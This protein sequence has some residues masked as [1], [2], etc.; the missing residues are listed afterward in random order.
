MQETPTLGMVLAQCASS[1]AAA[2]QH[3]R[4]SGELPRHPVSGLVRSDQLLTCGGPHQNNGG[5]H[6]ALLEALR[7]YIKLAVASTFCRP[8]DPYYSTVGDYYLF[9]PRGVDQPIYLASLAVLQQLYGL[10]IIAI[11][12]QLARCL[13]WRLAI[14]SCRAKNHPDV[15]YTAAIPAQD[16]SLISFISSLLDVW[17]ISMQRLGMLPYR[18]ATC[19]DGYMLPPHSLRCDNQP[20]Q[21]V[22]RLTAKDAQTILKGTVSKA[23]IDRMATLRSHSSATW[24]MYARNGRKT[25]RKQE[26]PQGKR[27][28]N[29]KRFFWMEDPAAA[30]QQNSGQA[31]PLAGRPV[32]EGAAAADSE[33]SGGPLPGSAAQGLLRLPSAAAV[34]AAAVGAGSL[35]HGSAAQGAAAVGAGSMSDVGMLTDGSLAVL[36]EHSSELL[37]GPSSSESRDSLSLAYTLGARLNGVDASDEVSVTALPVLTCACRTVMAR[38]HSQ[39]RVHIQCQ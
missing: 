24:S 19:S 33:G 25:S 17:A 30:Q 1:T 11:V 18:V 39:W 28:R 26:Q 23:D 5:T 15:V 35:A 29:H 10:D 2:H 16:A 37:T 3:L 27:Q 36:S 6:E 7:S 14:V 4:R 12:L 20:D 32:A 13:G 31:V 9:D 8:G 22:R 34:G 21:P 38:W